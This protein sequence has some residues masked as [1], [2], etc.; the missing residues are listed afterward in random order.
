MNQHYP[1]TL[2]P[3]KYAYDA[4][5]PYI[6]METM[7]FH[8]DRHLK[9]YVENLNKTL[10][11]YPQFQDWSLEQ[12]LTALNF[13]PKELQTPVKNNAGGVYNHELYF[14]TL[15]NKRTLPADRFLNSINLNFGNF[16]NLMD[17]MDQMALSVFGSGYAWLVIYGDDHLAIIWTPN[18]ECPLTKGLY[19]LLPVDVW[20]HA[21][22]LKH[23]NLRGDYLND[24]KHVINWDEV[25]NRYDTYQSRIV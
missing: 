6:D 13:L 20:E 7:H 18:Q 16:R 17:A 3:L 19:P 12:L 9:T 14:N 2:E 22:Y 15:T 4:L 24:W 8:H 11:P 23:Q 5:E 25:Q 10:E 21:Y 1:F